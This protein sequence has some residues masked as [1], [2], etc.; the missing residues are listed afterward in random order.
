MTAALGG[1]TVVHAARAADPADGSTFAFTLEN[2]LFGD[3]DAQY[4]NGIQL[5]WLSRD[6]ESYAGTMRVPRW[7]LKLIENTPLRSDAAHR[8]NVGFV[9]GQQMFTPTDI[10]NRALIT[11]DRP[12]AGWLYG[13]LS[14]V[15][16][17]S[18]ALDSLGLHVGVVGPWALAEEAQ[19]LVHEIRG[20]PT[21]NGWNHQL[22]NEPGLVLSYERRDR[23]FVGGWQ[24]GPGCD[25]ITNA[26]AAAG[27]V[28]T[29]LSAGAELRVGWNLPAD[30]GTATI[31]PGGEVSTFAS[32][33]TRGTGQVPAL[34]FH[35]FAGVNGRLVAR[36]I[37]LD[38]NSFADSHAVDK[39][40]VVGDYLLGASLTVRR[41]RIFYAQNF[42]T[43]EFE[44]Q[45][46]PHNFGSINLSWQF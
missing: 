27:N 26:S 39:R 45:R 19:D 2:D 37:F 25:F 34:G 4:T 28:Q 8:H 42:R 36:D 43:R 10:A 5:K 20:I 29:Y 12:Y 24:G 30:F 33:D 18:D 22:E 35:V 11:D 1:F 6:L 14:F 46:R 41:A 15:Q 44:G 9:L 40:N 13:G 31:R 23:W 16:R 38:G 21:A 17:S 7:I 32:F 3:T